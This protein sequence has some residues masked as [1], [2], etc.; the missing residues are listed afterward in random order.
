M[1]KNLIILFGT[2]GVGKSTVAKLI[3]KKGYKN[4]SIDK[5]IKNLFPEKN[6]NQLEE[7]ELI[8]GYKELGQKTKKYLLKNNVVVDEWFY[9][10][11]TFDIFLSQLGE[12]S[13]V[14]V[15]Y[16]HL[17]ADIKEI[18][19]RNNLK[20]NPLP[21]TDVKKQYFATHKKPGEYYKKL[22]PIEV[23]TDG[24]SP[25]EISDHLFNYLI[26][27][28]GKIISDEQNQYQ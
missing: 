25:K 11:K 9:N 10:N 28:D 19:K 14:N 1:T 27:H 21:E 22:K 20:K 23:K 26:F 8:R 24:L 17:V 2:T 18:I 13:K 16:F 12:T 6:N 3:S 15:F 4:V 5:I 7:K